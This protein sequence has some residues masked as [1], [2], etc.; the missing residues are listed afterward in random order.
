MAKT[1][2]TSNNKS[3]NKKRSLVKEKRRKKEKQLLHEI[4]RITTVKKINEKT[5]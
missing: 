3:E 1:R 5:T 2:M 4:V